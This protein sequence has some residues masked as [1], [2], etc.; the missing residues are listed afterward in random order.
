MM[1]QLRFVLESACPA[2]YHGGMTTEP[3]ET[4]RG[5]LVYHDRPRNSRAARSIQFR[6]TV[7]GRRF[8]KETLIALRNA[9]DREHGMEW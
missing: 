6:C 9:I 7:N 1:K 4:Y 5:I 8:Q 2:L 3:I